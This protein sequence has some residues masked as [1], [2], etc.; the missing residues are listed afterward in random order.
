[1]SGCTHGMPTP[2][3]CVDCML[4]GPVAPPKRA[5]RVAVV[6]VPSPARF[7]GHCNGC[8]LPICVGDAIV[9]LS[10]DTYRHERCAP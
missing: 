9:R 4:D 1:M 10:N 2:A 7:P 5:P 8:N 3:A 6:G